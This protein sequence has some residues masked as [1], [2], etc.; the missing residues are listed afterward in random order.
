MKW[1]G[2]VTGLIVSAG[3]PVRCAE[4]AKTLVV[5]VPACATAP[6]PVDYWIARE[7]ISYYISSI[8]GPQVAIK[9]HG[10]SMRAHIPCDM[11]RMPVAVVYIG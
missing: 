6:A 5:I 3:Q 4:H 10:V 9:I 2:Q 7:I 8:A 11:H 1:N